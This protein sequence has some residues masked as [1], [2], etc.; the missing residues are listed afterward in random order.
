MTRNAEIVTIMVDGAPFPLWKSVSVQAAMSKAVRTF[1]IE[2]AEASAGPFPGFKVPVG[3]EVTIHANGQLVLDGYVN[4]RSPSGSKDRHEISLAGRGK[5]QDYVDSAA[6]HETGEWE[7]ADPLQIAQDLAGRYGIGIAGRVPLERVDSFRLYQGERASAAVERAL[8]DQGATQMGLAN[9]DIEI[10]N[11]QAS[12]RHAGALIEG[13]NIQEYSGEISDDRRHSETI[14]RGQRRVGAGDS[15]LRIEERHRDA[16]VR[17][18]RPRILVPEADTNS[19]R[20][21]RRARHES[22]RVAGQSCK[23]RIK[24]QGWR[25]DGGQLWSPNFLVFVQSP[26]WLDINGDMLIE[27]INLTQSKQAGS[28]VSLALV[29]PSAYQGRAGRASQTDNEWGAD[30]E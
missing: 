15:N 19:G 2:A 3:A 22:N 29:H 10:T 25:D 21:R 16:G 30:E 8:R 23:C 26:N 27:Q 12:G 13:Y 20:S 17:R 9:G 7:N 28:H 6:M 5:G 24:T 4:R 18:F 11:G 14:V 1:T